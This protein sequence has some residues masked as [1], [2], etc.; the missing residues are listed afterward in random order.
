MNDKV[1]CIAWWRRNSN[2]AEGMFD[3][4]IEAGSE[5]TGRV[6]RT[7]DIPEMMPSICFRAASRTSLAS[8]S[9]TIP[10]VRSC[11]LLISALITLHQLRLR[12]CSTFNENT[13]GM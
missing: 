12:H 2:C 3:R 1:I 13:C 6:K 11:L 7:K 9:L 4:A 8:F 10:I 5:I